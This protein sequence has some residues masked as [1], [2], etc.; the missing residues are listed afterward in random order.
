MTGKMD[1]EEYMESRRCGYA[2]EM[3]VQMFTEEAG[4]AFRKMAERFPEER[5]KRFE[6]LFREEKG[7]ACCGASAKTEIRCPLPVSE[8][9]LMRRF[10]P[11]NTRIVQTRKRMLILRCRENGKPPVALRR[12]TAQYLTMIFHEYDLRM[13]SAAEALRRIGEVGK[14]PPDSLFSVQV[15]HEENYR[16]I[17]IDMYDEDRTVLDV[18]MAYLEEN[19]E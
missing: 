9:F 12:V 17:Q 8:A 11:D 10:A 5:L 1:L 16:P 3:L 2:N 4:R 15:V 14:L 7:V 18:I 19:E 6:I 13:N